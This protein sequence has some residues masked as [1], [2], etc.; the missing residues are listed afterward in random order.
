[1]F[2]LVSKTLLLFHI[3]YLPFFDQV[4]SSIFLQYFVS[5]FLYFLY[6]LGQINKKKWFTRNEIYILFYNMIITSIY[7][8]VYVELYSVDKWIKINTIIYLLGLPIDMY[9]SLN[10]W[11][12]QVFVIELPDERFY[13]HIY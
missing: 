12:K 11:F 13:E 9:Y 4:I 10:K 3:L 6:Y 2:G 7:T 8:Y 1:M 5:T